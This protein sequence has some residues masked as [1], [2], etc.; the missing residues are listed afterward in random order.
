METVLP[1]V[2]AK[3]AEKY[4]DRL[5]IQMEEDEKETYGQC[6]ESSMKVASGLSGLG[7]GK[8]DNVVIMAPVSLQYLHS[9]F[10][11]HSLGAVEVSINTAYRAQSLIHVLNNSKARL[12]IIDLKFI[13]VLHEVEDRLEYLEQAVFLESSETGRFPDFH[14]I[15]LIPFKDIEFANNGFEP[16]D[17]TVKDTAS[18]IYTSGTT[19]PAKGVMMPHGQISLLAKNALD[20][21]RLTENDV[22]HIFLPLFHMAGKF[23]MLYAAMMAGCKIVLDRKFIAEEWLTRVRK[24]GATI[25]GGHGP[26]LEMI[27]RQ[28]E[29]EDDHD[30]GL[31]AVF[32]APFPAKIAEGFEKRFGVKGIELW[33]MTEV[34]CPSYRPYDEPLRVG[35]CGKIL[36]EWYDVRLVDPN[37]DEKICVGEVGEIVVRPRYP[38]TTMQ[39]Y[40]GMPEKT[41]ESWRNLWFHTGD[42]AYFDRDG[43][44]Y[45]VDRVKDRI[46][47]RAEN[48]SSSEIEAAVNSHPFIEESAAVGVPSEFDSDDDIKVYIVVTKGSSLKPAELIRYLVSKLPHYMVPRYIQYIDK[49]PRTITNKVQKAQLSQLGKT[50]ATWDRKVEGVSIR[51]LIEELRQHV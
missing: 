10:A 42:M 21:F 51:N 9:W 19:G 38:W 22:Y 31:R 13:E 23:M 35:S 15:R 39:G 28:P 3:Q 37:T 11:V 32:A 40:F 1:K 16:V 6:Y 46:R 12:I 33:G 26:F 8:G 24:Y 5:F 14:K 36:N 4:R 18:I 48:I 30:N 41:V 43:Y 17:I 2:L 27:Y 7:I 50:D 49:L 25:S 29:Q 44:L 34:N 20:G 45:F 47:R